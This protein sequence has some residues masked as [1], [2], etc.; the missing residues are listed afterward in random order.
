MCDCT[1]SAGALRGGDSLAQYRLVARALRSALLL[2]DDAADAGDAAD[3]AAC[4]LGALDDL[5]P[6]LAAMR[7]APPSRP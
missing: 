2:A 7:A 6:A 4:V 3:A 5:A 1:A